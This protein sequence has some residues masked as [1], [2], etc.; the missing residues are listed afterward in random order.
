MKGGPIGSISFDDAD[1]LAAAA[2]ET[3]AAKDV[4]LRAGEDPPEPIVWCAE[5]PDADAADELVSAP[6]QR[7]LFAACPECGAARGEHAN[8]C[9]ECGAAFSGAPSIADRQGQRA[10]LLRRVGATAIGAC[11]GLSAALLGY[12]VLHRPAPPAA[13]HRTARPSAPPRR[14]AVVRPVQVAASA[15]AAPMLRTDLPPAPP[16]AAPV[17]ATAAA[18]EPPRL[19]HIAVHTPQPAKSHVIRAS[20]HRSEARI[21]SPVWVRRP[22]SEDLARLNPG[23]RHGEATLDCV[24]SGAGALTDC[25]VASEQPAGLGFGRAALKAAPMF[26]ADHL[27]T[28]GWPVAG[29]H[30]RVPVEWQGRSEAQPVSDEAHLF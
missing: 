1:A 30:V 22:S 17:L 19:R 5:H 21:Y 8:F 4:R 2:F 24:F 11:A 6:A 26:Q 12:A 28:A 20:A 7:P 14:L 10:T 18:H 25:A 3:A 15:P 13:P 29:Y 9:A 16:A 27:N 23:A